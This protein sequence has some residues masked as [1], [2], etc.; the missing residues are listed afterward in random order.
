MIAVDTEVFPYAPLAM[1]VAEVKYSYSLMLSDPDTQARVLE[2]VSSFTPIRE[3]S[4][5]RSVEIPADGSSPK[6]QTLELMQARSSNG[7][8]TAAVTAEALTVAM[9]GQ[10]YSRYDDSLGR[11]IQSAVTSLTEHAPG[12][13]ITRLGL[14]YLDE[15]RVPE[16]PADI[17]GWGTWVDPR[18]LWGAGLLA[19]IDGI[20]SDHRAIWTYSLPGDVQVMLN[21]GPFHG[22]GVVGPGHPFHRDTPSELM[23]VIDLDA[24]WTPPSGAAPL[25]AEQLLAH[26]D[27]L[28]QPAQAVFASVLTD[29]ARE[30]FRGGSDAQTHR[31]HG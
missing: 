30:L 14:R 11:L 24:S 26:Y 21:L 13:I 27:R 9:S 18:F 19:D 10:D 6:Q 23:F 20:A 1:V 5:H 22:S 16:P 12:G 3:R 4:E 31:A 8:T 15:I 2:G 25:D 17:A 7:Q 28:H 29:A